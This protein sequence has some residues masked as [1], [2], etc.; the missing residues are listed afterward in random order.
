MTDHNSETS[1][2]DCGAYVRIGGELRQA[3]LNAGM[4][5][6]D[7]S[8]QLHLSTLLIE[9][10]EQGRVDRLSPLYRRGYITNY[11]RALGLDPHP[12]LEQV[13]GED[14]QPELREVLPVSKRDWKFERYLRIATYALVTTVIVPPLLYFFIEGGS[15]IMERDPASAGGEASLSAESANGDQHSR[16]RIARAL[17]LDEN[18]NGR[19]SAEVGHVSASALPLGPVRPLRDSALPE[20]GDATDLLAPAADLLEIAAEDGRAAEQE[21]AVELLEDSW[22]EIHAAGGQ[23]LEYDLL[24]AG[25]VRSYRGEAPFQLLLGRASAVRLKLDGELVTYEGHDRGDVA[26]L[27][28]LAGGE[29][30]R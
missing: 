29:V 10:L 7:I 12:L 2:E 23:R 4:S 11:A 13:S 25:E 14:T 22:I 21:L 18:A 15:R 6:N 27:Q 17:A 1:N 19:D 28:L 26:R 8:R 9:D 20:P 5:T 16:N 30:E 24:R 3:R